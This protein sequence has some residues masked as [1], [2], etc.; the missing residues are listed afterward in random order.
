MITLN[1]NSAHNL[2]NYKSFFEDSASTIFDKYTTIIN[3]F[4]KH[5]N[6]NIAI[7]NTKSFLYII[8]KGLSIINYIF[9]FLLIYTKNLD[10]VYYNCQK[11]YIYYIEFIGQI[12]EENH[13]FL[14]LN[15][16]DA[17]LFVYKKTIFDINNEYRLNY[18]CDAVSD[19]ILSELNSFIN[20]YN[21]I[22][23][24]LLKSNQLIDIIKIMT[25]DT[26]TIMNKLM[27]IYVDP[28]SVN[29]QNKMNSV[30]IFITHFSN[31]ERLEYLELFIKKIK[32][33]N[34]LNTHKLQLFLLDNAPE[35]LSP[36]KYINNL[37]QFAN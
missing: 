16:N 36:V 18:I 6:E 2:D 33:I 30:N 26:R 13:T 22:L 17:A 4:L 21:T 12:S 9:Q 1:K 34:N 3:E 14:Q 5:A 32:R 37:L 7:Q 15:S 10:V 19:K 25:T 31:I 24:K 20:I 35:T 11:G 8:K 29:L 28:K 27:N 23:I